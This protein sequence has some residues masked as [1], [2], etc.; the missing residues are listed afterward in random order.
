[1]GVFIC[2][3]GVT[4]INIFTI[5][6]RGP[7]NVADDALVR[8]MIIAYV[9]GKCAIAVTKTPTILAYFGKQEHTMLGP[10]YRDKSNSS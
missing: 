4:V 1:M 2:G 7:G 10:D 9:L 3:N 6:G 8:F 5:R